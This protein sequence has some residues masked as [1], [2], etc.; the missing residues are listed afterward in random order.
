MSRRSSFL[1]DHDIALVSGNY[2]FFLR[3]NMSWRSSTYEDLDIA[4]S[5]GGKLKITAQLPDTQK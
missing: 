2:H 4:R 3:A 5:G 1:E